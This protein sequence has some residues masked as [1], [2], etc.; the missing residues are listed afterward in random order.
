L[1][2]EELFKKIV[3]ETKEHISKNYIHD[4][5]LNE[6]AG[7]YYITSSYLS[8]IFKEVTGTTFRK[9]LYG[10]RINQAKILLLSGKFKTMEQVS[11]RTGFK[12]VCYFYRVFN[13]IEGVTPTYYIVEHTE[14]GQYDIKYSGH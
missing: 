2:K 6:I 9:Y 7:K 8:K 5:T 3:Q 1:D 4:I 10:Y 13:K 14:A 11:S 12:D